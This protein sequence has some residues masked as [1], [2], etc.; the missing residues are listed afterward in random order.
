MRL[1]IRRTLVS[2]SRLFMVLVCSGVGLPI[3]CGT[4][5]STCSSNKPPTTEVT[6]AGKPPTTAAT[7]AGKPPT[8]AVTTAGQLP[9]NGMPKNGIAP[10]VLQ[11]NIKLLDRLKTSKLE[12]LQLNDVEPFSTRDLPGQDPTLEPLAVQLM[13]YIISFALD[14]G[15]KVS[16]DAN[17]QLYE[18]NG[19]MGVCASEQ[20]PMGNWFKSPPTNAC[21]EAVSASVLARV[22]ALNKVVVISMRDPGSL[23]ALHDKVPVEARYREK[24]SNTGKA[25]EIE[26]FS[27][28]S[29]EEGLDEATKNCGWSARYVGRCLAWKTGD[30]DDVYRKVALK[31]KPDP[32][33]TSTVFV[34]ACAGIHGCNLADDT[35]SDERRKYIKH[36]ASAALGG[37]GNTVEFACPSNG[38]RGKVAAGDTVEQIYG[39]FSIMLSDK[40]ID[41]DVE[42]EPATTE[43][44]KYPAV[45]EDVFRYREGAFY[46]S[47]F[48][49]SASSS[50]SDAGTPSATPLDTQYACFGEDWNIAAANIADRLCAIPN[51][52]HDSNYKFCFANEPKSCLLV[53]D[54]GV[55]SGACNK[56]GGNKGFVYTSCGTADPH[57]EYPMTTYLNHPC[58]LRSGAGCSSLDTW[59]FG[60][61]SI[62]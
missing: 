48:S 60:G 35:L 31:L 13:D 61:D 14:E 47:I 24:D 21:L 3:G 46:G 27:A 17:G 20:S 36:I 33:R 32:T 55:G 1:K 9:H 58:D 44:L 41:I 18:W 38:P 39:Y 49:T 53:G 45:E 26:S 28:C 50:A 56:S 52:L 37:Q 29:D 15:Q 43:G 57:W 4:C 2:I 12:G 34:R 6:T 42:P 25:P 8:T 62:P 10:A 19:H 23:I 16:V 51:P 7:T 11:A 30:P 59:T 54:A 40:N 22:N 5:E